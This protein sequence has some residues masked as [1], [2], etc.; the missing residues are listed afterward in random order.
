VATIE[1]E[2]RGLR[3]TVEADEDGYPMPMVID[4]YRPGVH[5]RVDFPDGSWCEERWPDGL[6]TTMEI[7]WVM[8]PSTRP[9]LALAWAMEQRERTERTM[10]RQIAQLGDGESQLA[11]IQRRLSA[12]PRRNEGRMCYVAERLRSIARCAQSQ[13]VAE[14]LRDL[15]DSLV[16]GLRRDYGGDQALGEDE[17]LLR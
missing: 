1:I 2:H 3:Y 15:A 9:T 8:S 5:E 11:E 14:E 16:S 7:R 10:R 6:G 13:A 4:H 12:I 17:N